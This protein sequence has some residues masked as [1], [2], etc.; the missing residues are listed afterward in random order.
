MT[1]QII[2][3]HGIAKNMRLSIAEMTREHSTRPRLAVVIVG[4][5]PASEIY[6]RNKEKACEECGFESVKYELSGETREQEV[7]GLMEKLN[8][9][10]RVNGILVQLPLPKH[11]DERRIILALDPG[12]DVDC[13]HPLNVGK[14][15]SSKNNSDVDIVPCTASGCLKL[16]KSVCPGLEGKNAVVI[17]RSNIVGKP[18]AQLLLN[19]NCTVTLAHSRTQNLPSI[20]KNADIVVVAIG[21][22]KF[23][24]G[25]MVREG[26]IVIDVGIN[27]LEDGSICGDVDFDSVKDICGF[28]SPVPRGVGPMTVACL[29]E[30]TYRLF[31]R[32]NHKVSEK[33]D[34][35]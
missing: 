17:G 10:E 1:V 20:A 33:S 11:I 31:L 29:M 22:A 2:D 30:N 3:G 16:I 35:C 13:F 18:T 15:F 5:N 28:L 34:K 6:I 21:K 19:E 24:N 7:L 4:N 8:R 12:K 26:A 23:L 32:Q 9:D 27:R 14:L 25:P